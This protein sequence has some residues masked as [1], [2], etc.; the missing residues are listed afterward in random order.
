MVYAVVEHNSNMQLTAKCACCIFLQH[1]EIL[2]AYNLYQYVLKML[3]TEFIQGKATW[4]QYLFHHI[5][6]K[7]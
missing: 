1:T 2:Y 5:A 4:H 7:K 6:L 3:I